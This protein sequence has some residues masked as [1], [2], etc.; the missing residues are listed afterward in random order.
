MSAVCQRTERST[1]RRRFGGRV[2]E[3]ERA[4]VER[5]ADEIAGQLV[6]GRGSVVRS[7]DAVDDVDRW[8]R[9]A[10][11]AGR[12]LG[13]PVRTGVSFDRSRVWAVDECRSVAV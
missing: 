9:A 8:R 6:A 3:L 2:V 7:S 11:R 13:V 1:D 12:I 10:R 4:R 5:L